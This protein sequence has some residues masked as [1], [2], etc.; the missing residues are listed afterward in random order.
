MGQHTDQRART[1]TLAR[2]LFEETD[3]KHPLPME[4]IVRRLEAQG[5]FAERKSIYR[6]L[7][8]LKRLGLE[9]VYRP[10][11]AGGWYLA[12]RPL[13]L[14]ELQAVADAVGVYP[15]LSE[16]ERAGLLEKL[17]ALLPRPLRPQL[18]RPVAAPSRAGGE[19]VGQTLDKL[20]AALQA[21]RAVRFVPMTRDSALTPV[22]AGPARMVSPKGLLW[23]GQRHI[24]L[25]WDHR[26]KSLTLCRPDRMAQL[27]LTGLPAQGPDADP[28][29][30]TAAP[31]GLEP[32]RRERITLH[33]RA[34]LADEIADRLGQ[35]ATVIPTGETFTV[36]ADVTI[37]PEFWGWLSAQ[38]GQ[39]DLVAPLWA[40]K[41]WQGRY[42][43]RGETRGRIKRT[44]VEKAPAQ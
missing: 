8:A 1:L 11:K 23:D 15:W 17:S 10:G 26:N 22:P 6:D 29:Q 28:A 4:E 2:V 16:G 32:E 31:F 39:A 24:L 44:D 21:G 27:T 5:V 37:G 3:E 14:E 33:C 13:G 41:L 18:R 35:K 40:A 30:W 9:T 43:P 12:A 36:I 25:A 34:A 19:Q 38:S 7:A 20:Y 42:R